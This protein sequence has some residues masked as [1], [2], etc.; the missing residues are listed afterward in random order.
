MSPADNVL[1]A[2]ST[3]DPGNIWGSHAGELFM[4]RATAIA[5]TTAVISHFPLRFWF[6]PVSRLVSAEARFL[7]GRASI[8]LA[9]FECLFL[10]CPFTEVAPDHYGSDSFVTGPAML[11]LLLLHQV[12]IN[13]RRRKTRGL[14]TLIVTC[15]RA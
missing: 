2:G 9:V 4:V 7:F 6:R 13:S 5:T 14:V 15:C 8:G 3:A 1:D 12:T 11:L 10:V